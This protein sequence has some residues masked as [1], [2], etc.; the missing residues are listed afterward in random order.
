MFRYFIIVVALTLAGCAGDEHRVA[1]GGHALRLR[2][3]GRGSPT[4]VFESGAGVGLAT[5]AKVQP[6][7]ARFTRTIAYDRAGLGKSELGPGPRDARRIAGE[8]HTALRKV[9]AEPPYIL[10][11]HSS[12]AFYIRYFADAYPGEVAGLV[13]V[14]PATEQLN[15]WFKTHAPETLKTS[16]A[17]SK[18]SPGVRAEWQAH[19][20]T[21][22]QIR[23]IPLPV[24]LP[25]RILSSK[26]PD[27][28]HLPG[29]VEALLKSHIELVNNLPKSKHIVTDKSG[30]NIQ[31]EEPSLVVQAIQEIVEQIG[32]ATP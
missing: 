15:D 8:L 12:G 22:E 27:P 16:V 28:N 13:F 31:Q 1:V 9:G 23:C 26:R 24:H 19:V 2:L 29:F 17:S 18:M 32:Q 7:A 3:Q 30:H 14:D 20:L 25:A 4:V 5:W 11:G 10:V 6:R 21:A